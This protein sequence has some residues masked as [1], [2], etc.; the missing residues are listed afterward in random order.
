[1][2]TKIGIALMLSKGHS[3]VEIKVEEYFC[4]DYTIYLFRHMNEKLYMCSEC[5][6]TIMSVDCP[7]PNLKVRDKRGKVISCE[8]LIISSVLE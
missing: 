3:W 2:D 4:D 1:L 6:T 5:K 8:E 7:P